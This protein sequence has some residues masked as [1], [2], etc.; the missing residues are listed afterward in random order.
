[1]VSEGRQEKKKEGRKEKK[2]DEKQNGKKFKGV[3]LM[4]VTTS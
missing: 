4:F 1:M 3:F 2:K